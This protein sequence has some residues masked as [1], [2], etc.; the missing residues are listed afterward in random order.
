MTRFS[1][2]VESL[3]E[4]L[5]LT[6]LLHSRELRNQMTGAWPSRSSGRLR[7]CEEGREKT[8]D[9]DA[10]LTELARIERAATP[11]VS[12]YLNTR[13]GD[14]HQRDRVRVFLKNELAKARRASESR[15]D[16]S[17]LDWIAA[18]GDSIV[19][20][21]HFPDAQGVALF[22]CRALGLREALPVRV[23]FPDTFVVG[24][25]PFLRP[26]TE[27]VE[28]T[29]VALVV[30]VDTESARLIPLTL[31]GPGEEVRLESEVPGRHSR[32]GWAQ[33][34]QSGYQRHIAEHRG[35]HFEAVAES[36]S[37]LVEQYA[38]KRI[39][40]SGEPKN[41]TVFRKHLP[42]RIDH[43]VVGVVAG[44]RHEPASAIVSRASEYLGHLEGQ[45]QATQVDALL[46]E[47]AKSRQAV[48][49][50]DETLDAVNRGAIDRLYLL[51][52]FREIGTTCPACG[53]LQRGGQPACRYCG[54]ET[55]TVELG[56][57]LTDRVIAAQGKAEMVDSHQALARVG[58]VTAR[59]RFPL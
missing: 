40:L 2:Q 49:G 5:A 37:R 22:A 38:V 9:L 56:E 24:E 29:P 50:V 55:T 48:A 41:V 19:A 23:S 10:R 53:A 59:L 58:G 25:A 34:A 39:V 17:D 31:E 33:L 15:A 21:E 8:M 1:N 13:W 20:Q 3:I 30:F 35:R 18:A 57:A 45:D 36:L 54:K 46:T 44:A 6:L 52:G 11:V 12:V 47:A 42:A 14:Q 51:K 4:E 27:V 26:L 32:G 28:Q 16:E 7:L 43:G